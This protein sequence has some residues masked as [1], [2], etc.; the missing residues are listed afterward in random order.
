M[1][2]V[3]LATVGRPVPERELSLKSKN[4]RGELIGNK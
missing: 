4:Q 3:K 1:G 2:H